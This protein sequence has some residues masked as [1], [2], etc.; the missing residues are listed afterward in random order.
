MCRRCLP[1]ELQLDLCIWQRPQVLQAA[2]P[3]LVYQ[4]VQDHAY[5]R[6]LDVRQA[7]DPDRSLHC[8]CK[9]SML[10]LTVLTA[11]MQAVLVS[12]KQ[13]ARIAAS[14]S[15]PGHL[16]AVS[17]AARKLTVYS[18]AA[19]ERQSG[20]WPQEV[21]CAARRCTWLG[22]TH[23]LPGREGL[24]ERNKGALRRGVRCVL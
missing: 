17:P 3:A 22:F 8:P 21:A 2:C 4:R 13:P 20:W 24:L 7:A 18:I 19:C 1:G 11:H 9:G 14:L 12:M 10:S 5:A 15:P 6:R 23:S 16:D